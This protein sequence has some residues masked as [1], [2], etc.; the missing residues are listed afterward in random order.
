M[1]KTVLVTGAT[2]TLGSSLSH[3]LAEGGHRVRGLSRKPHQGGPVVWFAGN[4]MN[5]TGVK[6]AV[7]GVDAIV[8]CATNLFHPAVEV[9]GTQ[10]MIGAAAQAGQPH[11][12]YISIVGADR[13]PLGYYRAKVEAESKVERSGL[14]WTILRATQFHQLVYKVLEAITRLPLVVVPTDT[15][16]QPVGAAE[17][18]QVLA[19]LA[20]GHERQRVPD[21][22][23]PQIR[24]AANLACAYLTAKGRR[25]HVMRASIP[26]RIADGYRE[27]RHLTPDHARGRSTWEQF[28]AALPAPARS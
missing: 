3:C 19:E 18:A 20:V 7:A 5:G 13:I 9:A 4:L 28:L 26:G 10:E 6:S 11:F 21:F 1:A 14:P 16:F 23:G 25:R 2:G 17:V 8:H 22:G 24:S 12:V 15:S 27:G